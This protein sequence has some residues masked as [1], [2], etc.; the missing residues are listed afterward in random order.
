MSETL[1]HLISTQGYWVVAAIVGLESMGIPL[2]GETVLVTAGIYAGTTHR[3]NIALVIGAAAFGAIVGDNLGFWIGRRFGYGLVLRYA[4]LLRLTTG[5][6]KLGQYL[7]QSHGGKVVFFGRFIA[8]LR[9]LSALLAGINWMP[10]WRFLCF[11]MA[12][13][14]VWATAFGWSSYVLGQQIEQIRG[15]VSMI[16]IGLACFAAVVG[17]WFVRRHETELEAKAERALPGPVQ[18]IRRWSG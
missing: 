15:P 6:I 16:G 4:P 17:I 8:I 3:L 1:V 9:T 14:V 13:G 2:P 7:F 12:G 5:R 10:W 18:P 11:N